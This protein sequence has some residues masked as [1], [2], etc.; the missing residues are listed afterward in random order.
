M[1]A[2]RRREWARN[3]KRRESVSDAPEYAGSLTG[4]TSVG[5][6][7]RPRNR[8]LRALPPEESARL[9]PHLE[10]VALA[11]LALLA[12]AGAPIR[13][14]YFPETGVI[15]LLSRSDD[16]ALIENGTVGHEGMVGFPLVLGVDWTASA[17][18]SEVPGVSWRMDA[19][20]FRALLP[21]L[22]ALE[23]SLRRYLA[24]L[25][26]Q[27]AQSLACNGLHPVEQRCAR[28]LLMTHDRVEGDEFLLT[29]DVVAQMLAVRRAGVSVAFEG[30]RD[31]GVIDY[32]RGRVTVR[33]RAGLEAAACECYRI[34]CG[35]RDRLLAPLA[36]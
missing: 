5:A 11:P 22:P 18:M 14:V 10:P 1:I 19:A 17:I 35:H 20:V 34:V 27:I 29:H 13:H 32:R 31:R 7:P 8:L 6:P 4:P 3:L 23:A 16:G 2:D 33:D 36:D 30:L 26:A 28:W 24:Y 25:F 21:E 15:S 9:R 12:P